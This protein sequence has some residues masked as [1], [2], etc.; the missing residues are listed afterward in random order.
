MIG[1]N[2][3]LP[4]STASKAPPPVATPPPPQPAVT[5]LP[6]NV[7]APPEQPKSNF[8]MYAVIG[9]FIFLVLVAVAC[10][11]MFF[12]KSKDTD[13]TVVEGKSNIIQDETIEIND[14]SM[15]LNNDTSSVEITKK[16]S[17]KP[18][19]TSDTPGG[20]EVAWLIGRDGIFRVYHMTDEDDTLRSVK[21][22]NVT[23][24]TKLKGPYTYQFKN[25]VFS[26]LNIDKEDVWN[27]SSG[28][29]VVDTSKTVE[30]TVQ[31]DYE[32][33][34]TSTDNVSITEEEEQEEEE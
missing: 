12:N 31:T 26:V 2:P 8:M 5:D 21:V 16:G 13:G 14:Y 10:Y 23:D 30:P 34:N 1:F 29:L 7:A 20:S 11:F 33:R 6:V 18:L 3:P 19:W 15:S 22:A 28:E 9:F 17:D 4:I 32:L 25:G 27:T 24:T